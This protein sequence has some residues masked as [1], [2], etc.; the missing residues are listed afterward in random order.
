[1]RP[2][3]SKANP[4]RQPIRRRALD[5][6]LASCRNQSDAASQEL[7]FDHAWS[8]PQSGQ[9]IGA[10]AWKLSKLEGSVSMPVETSRPVFGQLIMTMAMARPPA[11]VRQTNTIEREKFRSGTPTFAAGDART[12]QSRSSGAGIRRSEAPVRHCRGVPPSPIKSGWTVSG[13]NQAAVLAEIF[14]RT[15]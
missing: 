3:V 8:R 1:L 6:N 15:S 9:W 2:V 10:V 7:A 5:G 14:G 12:V 13:S 4:V 11:S